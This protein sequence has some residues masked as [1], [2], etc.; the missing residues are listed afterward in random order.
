MRLTRM[1]LSDLAKPLLLVVDRHVWAGI[2]L[3]LIVC[4]AWA[5]IC[6]P[7]FIAFWFSGVADAR[8]SAE[9]SLYSGMVA[10]ALACWIASLRERLQR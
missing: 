7:F 9:W 1:I 6:L 4:A 10:V 5:T 2:A 3:G 8:K